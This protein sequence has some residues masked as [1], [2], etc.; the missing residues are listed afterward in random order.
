M[1]RDYYDTIGYK[2]IET[3]NNSLSNTV[4][5]YSEDQLPC[6]FKVLDQPRLNKFLDDLGETRARAFAYKA[7]ALIDAFENP[8][9]KYLTFLDADMV[10]FRP[11][12]DE[13]LDAL[14]KDNLIVYVGVTH[15]TYG[16]HCDSC[17][18]ILNT[19]HL[20]YNEFVSMYK[21]IY[22]SRKILNE[23]L[24]V[25]PNDSYVLA[26]C[27]NQAEQQ[28]HACIDLHPE[29][30]SLS[31]IAETVLGTYIRHFKASRK[32]NESVLKYVDKAI[33]GMAKKKD[34]ARIL[35]LFDR[36]IRRK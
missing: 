15:K 17:F 27:I 6:E 26:W 14:I 22:E 8:K 24:F 28:G 16:S 4:E 2:M 3:F 23:D 10:C 11:I 12:T 18:F 36:R 9:K 20:Y 35:E 7:Y 25:K 1:S 32:I 19:E 30:K 34:P 21:D 5:V 33:S 13:F 31:P 29:R